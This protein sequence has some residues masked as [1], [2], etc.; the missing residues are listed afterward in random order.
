M[1]LACKRP[2]WVSRKNLAIA[3]IIIFSLTL[4]YT[5]QYELSRWL[6]GPKRRQLSIVHETSIL[7]TNE[8]VWKARNMYTQHTQFK[9]FEERGMSR[10]D[11][12]NS[13]MSAGNTAQQSSCMNFNS[14]FNFEKCVAG[15]N[16]Y[17][18]PTSAEQFVSKMYRLILDAVGNNTH[19]TDDPNKACLFVLSLDTLDRDRLSPNYMKDLRKRLLHLRYWNGG[20]NH[21]IFN[22]FSGTW[23]DYSDDL[24]FDYGSAMI[25]KASFSSQAYR[26]NYDVSL[27]LLPKNFP[28]TQNITNVNKNV[29]LFPIRRKYLLVFKGK[30]YLTGIGSESRNVLHLISNDKD[31]VLLTSCRHN[32]KEWDK[33]KDERCD[34]DNEKHDR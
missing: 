3:L 22:M 27:P 29:N 12:R 28:L 6:S 8:D 14:C 24:S 25:A 10:I 18:H 34:G 17:L 11:P 5:L 19:L 4:L 23:P 16:V 26:W 1:L 32:G 21:V 33:L 15:F 20:A 30:R 7:H 2:P 31:I 13:D 9:D